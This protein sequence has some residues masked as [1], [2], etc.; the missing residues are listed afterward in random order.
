MCVCF[1]Y[2]FFFFLS[3]A[4]FYLDEQSRLLNGRNITVEELP[5]IKG[6]YEHF[7][8]SND[9]F[10][11]LSLQGV[12]ELHNLDR[13]N[14]PYCLFLL[15]KDCLSETS[16]NL[17]EFFPTNFQ[18]FCSFTLFHYFPKHFHVGDL[19]EFFRYH[20][21]SAYSLFFFFSGLFAGNCLNSFFFFIGDIP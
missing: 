11:V 12:E 21:S 13:E 20:F 14:S 17:N 1:F 4:W 10:P 16:I 15:K 8:Q 3:L 19:L 2:F 5:A 6:E 9:V 18:N 7:H